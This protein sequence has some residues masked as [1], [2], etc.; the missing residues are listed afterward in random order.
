M[1]SL[2]S[3]FNQV[4]LEGAVISSYY[5]FYDVFR[6]ILEK[7]NIEFFAHSGT[8]LGA[9]R[10]QGIIPWDDDLDVMIEEEFESDF[11]AIVP[12]LEEVGL[13]LKE[14]LCEHLYQF[15]CSNPKICPTG[16][17]LQIDVFIG[18][19]EVVSGELVLHYKTP[20]F[21]KWFKD[22]YI[23]VS[24]VY[25][26]KVYEFGPLSIKGIRMYQDYFKRSGFSLTSAIVA[27]HNNFEKFKPKI[28]ELKEIGLYPIVDEKILTFRH[29]VQ[30]EDVQY[31]LDYY[32]CPNTITVLTYGTFDLFHIGHVRLLSRLRKL[33]GKLIVGLSTDKFNAEKGKKSFYSYEE[34]REILLATEFVDDVFPE[35][36]W[37]QK[38]LDIKSLGVTILGMGDDWKGKFD[39]LNE[40]CRVVYLER[41]EDISTTEIK[42]ALSNINTE[43]IDSLESS[44]ND[45]LK[46]VRSLTLSV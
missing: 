32:N 15:K 8:M 36:N 3:F 16:T 31:P 2:E 19:R 37:G 28:E 45:A 38:E 1:G 12:Q 17:Y 26:L 22:R 6:K 44:L 27:R 40:I 42:K 9:V 11:L 24:D 18:K 20:E 4:I 21:R 14:K 5:R 34:R 35:Q 7:N 10:H 13:I 30:L 25:P 43:N 23:K 41:T 29:D 39:H 33:G 46:V